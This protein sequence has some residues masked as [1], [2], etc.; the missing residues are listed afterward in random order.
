MCIALKEWENEARA[1]GEAKGKAKDRK[2]I[3]LSMFGK[4]VSATD[5]A[6]LCDIPY[7]E[8]EA[9]ISTMHA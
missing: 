3:I 8:V 6:Y 2:H 4:G 7:E 9:V 5:I 1:E